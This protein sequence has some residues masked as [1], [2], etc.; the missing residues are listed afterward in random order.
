MITS[1]SNPRI[2]W[3][4]ALQAKRRA[5]EEEGLFVVEGVRLAREVVQAGTAVRLVLHTDRLDARGR[6]L[7]NSLARLGAEVEVVSEPVMA[8]CS[9]TE[10]P[11]GLLVVLPLPSLPLPSPLDLAVVADGLSD[12]GNLGSLLRT[13]AAAAVQAVFLTEGTVDPYNPKVVRGG[14]GAHFRLCIRF[15]TGEELRPHLEGLRLWR[16]EPGQG[17][18]YHQVDWRE[19]SA[20]II[21]GEARGPGPGLRTLAPHPVQIP[22]P[23]GME[24]LNAAV[25][26][27]VILFEALR[28][29]GRP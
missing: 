12:P 19:P 15:V 1:T 11:P 4:R 8:A 3:V 13:A 10:T 18:P 20:L 5:R 7:V 26:A 9:S 24:S 21:G 22:M 14:M 27:A 29:R 2:R 6:G 17:V 23:G 28:Q 25:A 16:A